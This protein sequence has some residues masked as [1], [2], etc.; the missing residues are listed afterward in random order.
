MLN[1]TGFIAKNV[2]ILL[3][4]N[5]SVQKE[6]S[7]SLK[8]KYNIK[9]IKDNFIDRGRYFFWEAPSLNMLPEVAGR[10]K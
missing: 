5:H 9:W 10:K 6:I 2:N 4:Q 1:V 7:L 8:Q 3:A